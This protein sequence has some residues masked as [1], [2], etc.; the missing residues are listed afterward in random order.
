[1]DVQ[2]SYPEKNFVLQE[3]ADIRYIPLET[4][5]K[6]LLPTDWRFLRF[7]GTDKNGNII[8]SS[9]SGFGNEDIFT[10]DENGKAVRKINRH[11]HGNGEYPEIDKIIYDKQADELLVYDGKT[12]FV[13]SPDGTYKR[14]FDFRVESYISDVHPIDKN[15][16]AGY[17]SRNK[18]AHPL[19]IYSSSDG[20][21]IENID[22]EYPER[23]FEHLEVQVP[24]GDGRFFT[25]VRG[26]GDK[27]PLVRVKEG[28]IVNEASSDTIYRL[29]RLGNLSPVIARV[30]SVNSMATP[31]FLWVDYASDRYYFM[32]QRKSDPAAEVLPK[33]N[34]IYDRKDGNI[35]EG[36]IT[37]SDR[38][39]MEPGLPD[40]ID[41]RNGKT[42]LYFVLSPLRLIEAL[43]KGELSGEL[44]KIAESVKEDDNVVLMIATFKE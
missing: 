34:L 9:L 37:D 19:A 38:N 17:V 2:K 13:Y 4:S 23:L 33:R 42:S 21:V 27:K 30:P 26:A 31:V 6:V 24:L 16:M 29:G 11:G 7:G 41:S 1:M 12:M 5:D 25:Q 43:E 28:L 10:F 20:S 39:G 8:I 3:I 22:M 15:R 36:K 44:K 14:S 40:L 35:Y 18:V 32:T